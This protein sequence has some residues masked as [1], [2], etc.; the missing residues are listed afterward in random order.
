MTPFEQ[1]HMR[2]EELLTDA[3]RDV[4][5]VLRRRSGLEGDDGAGLVELLRSTPREGSPAPRGTGGL[6]AEIAAA[7]HRV[8]LDPDLL[9]DSFEDEEWLVSAIK[10][11]W[12]E[13][14]DSQIARAYRVAAHVICDD[15]AELQALLAEMEERGDLGQ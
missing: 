6:E 5:A 10:A 13:A 1:A 4:A 8:F 15:I 12:P 7:L 2:R 3:V 14:T 9:C 11:R